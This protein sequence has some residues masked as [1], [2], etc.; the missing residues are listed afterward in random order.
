MAFW[1][2]RVS[3]LLVWG[4]IVF[5]FAQLWQVAW[6]L[7]DMKLVGV[8]MVVTASLLYIFYKRYQHIRESGLSGVELVRSL[9]VD[10]SGAARAKGVTREARALCV[11]FT[12]D[13]HLAFRERA[14]RYGFELYPPPPPPPPTSSV[15]TAAAAG[16]N[17]AIGTVGISTVGTV[18]TVGATGAVGTAGEGIEEGGSDKG[19]PSRSRARRRVRWPWERKSG[20][21]D[22]TSPDQGNSGS[23]GSAQPDEETP[24]AQG[25]IHDQQH[26]RPRSSLSTA[27]AASGQPQPQLSTP[28]Y[29]EPNGGAA[30]GGGGGGRGWRRVIQASELSPSCSVCLFDYYKDEAVTLLPCSHLYHTECI[31]IWMRS[32]VD[33]PFCRADI[34]G[35][36]SGGGGGGTRPTM[37]SSGGI[38]AAAVDTRIWT[39]AR[40]ATVPRE[41][42]AAAAATPAAQGQQGN[43]SDVSGGAIE[44]GNGVAGGGRV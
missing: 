14:S 25:E 12:Y 38:S 44:S 5:I 29:F 19:S 1:C 21:E 32:H 22:D 27:S 4:F 41:A 13:P 18:G 7:R 10:N 40:A 26:Q 20:H 43:G 39:R 24:I 36:N 6:K 11:D 34:N 28:P 23:T 2:R 9:A 31:N 37:E 8:C 30:A 17:G 35:W 15:S 3:G 16:P 42:T 33:C